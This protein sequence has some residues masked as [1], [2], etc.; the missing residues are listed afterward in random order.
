MHKLSAFSFLVAAFLTTA[1]AAP[2][3]PAALAVGPS[4]TVV[5]G[6]GTFGDCTGTAPGTLLASLASPFVTS[7]GTDSGTLISAVYKE[8][9]GTLDFY[10]QVV[11][12]T[13]STNCGTAGKPAFDPIARE[14]NI[15]FNNAALTTTYAATPGDPVGP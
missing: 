6:A 1:A 5:L 11:L 15:N 3:C 4:G 12:N 7:T 14:P 8:S 10:Y 13:T 2:L 9:G